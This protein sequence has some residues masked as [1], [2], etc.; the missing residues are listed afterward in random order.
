M[1]SAESWR[2]SHS[3]RRPPL[4]AVVVPAPG[5]VGRC[6]VQTTGALRSRTLG[7]ARRL[8][9]GKVP[10]CPEDSGIMGP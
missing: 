5:T 6:M 10:K 9:G 8:L 7:A 1:S 3:A 2:L 4:P